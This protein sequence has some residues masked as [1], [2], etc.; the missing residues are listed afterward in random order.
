MTKTIGDQ[1]SEVRLVAALAGSIVLLS[2]WLSGPALAA[3]GKEIDVRV[4]EALVN[5][6]KE[7]KGGKSFLESSKGV[8]AFPKV[9]KGAAVWGESTEKAHSGSVARQWITTVLS[10]V[11]LD[12]NSGERSR[13]SLWC[14]W[15]RGP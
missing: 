5:F 7:V 13:P 4:D 3:S 12:S 14:F 8:L 1:F 2:G 11:H 6:E 10:R 9:F 15:K